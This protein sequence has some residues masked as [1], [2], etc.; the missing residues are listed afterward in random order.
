ME[1]GTMACQTPLVLKKVEVGVFMLEENG[2]G[3]HGGGKQRASGQ[4]K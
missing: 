2:G 1:S 4:A 3:A